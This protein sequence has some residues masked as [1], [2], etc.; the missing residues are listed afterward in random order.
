MKKS[1]GYW[2]YV[3]RLSCSFGGYDRRRKTVKT[4][5]ASSWVSGR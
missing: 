4:A 1:F 5:T 2:L 3:G